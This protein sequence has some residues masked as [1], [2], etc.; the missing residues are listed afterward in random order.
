MEFNWTMTEHA[1][2]KWIE[3]LGSGSIWKK[4]AKLAVTV[5]LDGSTLQAATKDDLEKLGFQGIH[6]NRILEV[7]KRHREGVDSGPP[8]QVQRSAIRHSLMQSGCFKNGFTPVAEEEFAIINELREQ[9][10]LLKEARRRVEGAITQ[11]QQ[12]QLA[13][14]KALEGGISSIIKRLGVLK[15]RNLAEMD[16]NAKLLTGNLKKK[17]AELTSME[18]KAGRVERQCL[19]TLE[20]PLKGSLKARTQRIVK[21]GK[22]VTSKGVPWVVTPGSV[23]T[24]IRFSENEFCKIVTQKSRFT[25]RFTNDSAPRVHSITTDVSNPSEVKMQFCCDGSSKMFE[26]RCEQHDF[27]RSID[28]S[29]IPPSETGWNTIILKDLDHKVYNFDLRAQTKD[30]TWGP[31]LA[32]PRIELPDRTRWLGWEP[33]YLAI[34]DDRKTVTRRTVVGGKKCAVGPSLRTGIHHVRFKLSQLSG[35]MRVGLV[36]SAVYNP[37]IDPWCQPGSYLLFPAQDG[38]K[39]CCDGEERELEGG[40]KK[41][42]PSTGDIVEVILD[43]NGRVCKFQVNGEPVGGP[44][45]LNLAYHDLKPL[46]C[47]SI[48][49]GSSVTLL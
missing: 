17:L 15:M 40:N 45:W 23:V 5:C 19:K 35:T 31:W 33:E 34:T 8:Q 47:L 14:K 27:V 18:K 26:L 12:S 41:I 3:T 48:V 46:A 4:Y 9:T 49:I 37:K 30:G 43:M 11:V 20:T 13:A 29:R 7:V 39:L 25:S 44:I 38:M 22:N 2:A 21:L 10:K 28:T 36:A 16:R 24:D 42:I 32:C 1:V 6:A